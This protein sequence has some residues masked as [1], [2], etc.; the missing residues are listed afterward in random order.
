MYFESGSDLEDYAE[1]ENVFADQEEVD[2]K[3]EEEDD[4]IM[5]K[6]HFLNSKG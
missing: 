3:K 5:A 2:K 6:D 4:R 1:A